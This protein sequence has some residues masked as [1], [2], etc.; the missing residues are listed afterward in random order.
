[1]VRNSRGLPG[2]ASRR[3]SGSRNG[4]SSFRRLIKCKPHSDTQPYHGDWRPMQEIRPP[5]P[6]NSNKN[7][8]CVDSAVTPEHE[9][10][11]SAS[12]E[13]DKTDGSDGVYKE[14]VSKRRAPYIFTGRGIED[15]NE[16]S[17]NVTT[18]VVREPSVSSTESDDDSVNGD[19]TG[20]LNSDCRT[21]SK[22]RQLSFK[23]KRKTHVG[24]KDS[25]GASTAFCS[26]PIESKDHFATSGRRIS[27]KSNDSTKVASPMNVLVEHE[28]T[29]F[30]SH[31]TTD[32][33]GET[34]PK[35]RLSGRRS[36][37]KRLLKRSTSEPAELSNESKKGNEM[38][39]NVH[40][41]HSLNVLRETHATTLLQDE[42]AEKL[43]EKIED[44]SFR[45]E[46]RTTYDFDDLVPY[47]KGE[48]A[49]SKLIRFGV[50][51]RTLR[52]RKKVDSLLRRLGVDVNK[53]LCLN[54]KG[55]CYFGHDKFVIV[56]EVPNNS[57][58]VFIY[59]MLHRL[60][61]QDNAFD[62]MYKA[63]RLNYLQ[64]ETRGACIS[65]DGDELTLSFIAPIDAMDLKE[66]RNIV[67]NFIELVVDLERKLMGT[68]EVQL[69]EK[70]DE[71]AAE[72][73][74][75]SFPPVNTEDR[76]ETRVE[77]SEEHVVDVTH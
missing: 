58:C 37:F 71:T 62:L 42:K 21:R 55:I 14:W 64:Q 9:L 13:S 27:F 70:L 60:I 40:H 57:D 77:A 47:S 52:L 45:L 50:S 66:F 32:T 56:V 35:R 12:R 53:D 39:T 24:K 2:I 41:R 65:M 49:K 17:P 68:D 20:L 74:G 16:F 44:D 51:E 5:T 11:T 4:R 76:Y 30:V 67:G 36:S 38:N 6:K 26:L 23:A 18:N 73:R 19:T 46:A 7:D 69:V 34:K 22:T 10:Y 43:D 48:C 33:A 72:V 59:S 61:A 8:L 75:D 29:S 31:E 63:L 54:P 25:N 1:M 28:E 3:E 15:E